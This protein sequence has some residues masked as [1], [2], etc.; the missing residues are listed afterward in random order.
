[1]TRSIRRERCIRETS[2]VVRMI[3]DIAAFNTALEN[4]ADA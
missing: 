1:M 2:G 4:Q 3:R